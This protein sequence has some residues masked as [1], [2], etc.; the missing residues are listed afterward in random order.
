MMT[1]LPNSPAPSSNTREAPGLSGVPNFMRPPTKNDR[2]QRPAANK[3]PP[4]Y[5]VTICSGG[6]GRERAAERG[7][8]AGALRRMLALEAGFFVEIVEAVFQQARLRLRGMEK[9][10]TSEI[11]AVVLPLPRDARG[12]VERPRRRGRGGG[13]GRRGG[14]GGRRRRRG[15]P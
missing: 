12:E 10:H 15:Q 14:G 5:S 7:L 8:S 1:S 4:H 9:F 11:A 6:I 13:G 2:S 3:R